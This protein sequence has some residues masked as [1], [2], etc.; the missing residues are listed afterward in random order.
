[1]EVADCCQ[2]QWHSV[3]VIEIMLSDGYELGK[4]EVCYK[5]ESLDA[6]VASINMDDCSDPGG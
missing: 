1:M 4:C 2:V 6:P 5:Y 3:L